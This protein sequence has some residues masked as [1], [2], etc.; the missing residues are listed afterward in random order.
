MIDVLNLCTVAVFFKCPLLSLGATLFQTNPI[1]R[2]VNMPSFIMCLTRMYDY[3]YPY[4][5]H[6]LA[7]LLPDTLISNSLTLNGEIS[8]TVGYKSASRC[9]ETSMVLIFLILKSCGV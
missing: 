2:I 8:R 4:S 3:L 1:N 9:S 6:M 5:V 7:K